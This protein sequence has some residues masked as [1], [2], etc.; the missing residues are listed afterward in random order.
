[1]KRHDNGFRHRGPSVEQE[2]LIFEPTKDDRR[3]LE[4]S[5]HRLKNSRC[6]LH[7]RC[8]YPQY[9]EGK[10]HHHQQR[11]KGRHYKKQKKGGQGKLH[12]QAKENT[13]KLR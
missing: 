10:S 9:K 7:K 12:S 8:E 4:G 5:I 11:G 2:G 1:M 13:M 6:E 3:W